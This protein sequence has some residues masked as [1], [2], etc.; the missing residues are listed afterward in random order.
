MRLERAQWRWMCYWHQVLL[1][2]F[3]NY[4]ESA[5]KFTWIVW[6]ESLWNKQRQKKK[7]AAAIHCAIF[8]FCWYPLTLAASNKRF[9][10]NVNYSSR[11]WAIV[12]MKAVNNNLHK[13]FKSVSLSLCARNLLC[14]AFSMANACRNNTSWWI[15]IVRTLR[16]LQT[17][18]DM[19][20]TCFAISIHEIMFAR[21]FEIKKKNSK[22]VWESVG[23]FI[24]LIFIIS[25]ANTCIHSSCA[26]ALNVGKCCVD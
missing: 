5:T 7:E 13:Y 17:V 9:A 18:T 6:K 26:T 20:N 3:E 11:L 14:F 19:E 1:W 8:I 12:S 25:L 16:H 15:W 4:Y 10:G 24:C 23:F 2:I 21:M 22:T